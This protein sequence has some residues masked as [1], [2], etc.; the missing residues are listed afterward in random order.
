MKLSLILVIGLLS[1]ATN[2]LSS[3]S[4]EWETF[5]LEHEKVYKDET[6]EEMRQ[7][8]W[9]TNK[10][11]I[12]EHNRKYEN[13]EVSF[14]MALNQFSDLSSAEFNE[15]YTGRN[16][17]DSDDS[18]Q[19]LVVV[20][21]TQEVSASLDWRQLGAVTGVKN[22]SP[23]GTCYAFST[24]GAIEG[25]LFKSTRQLVSLS[26]QQITDCSRAYGNGGCKGKGG[27]EIKAYNYIKRVGGI[28][29]E[30][31]YPFMAR[32]MKCKFNR[33]Y[34]AAKVGGH[35]KFVKT[36][37]N[38][39]KAVAYYGPIAV[40]IHAS[41]SL[42]HYSGGV[43]DDAFSC[44]NRINHAVLVVGYGNERGKDYWLVKNSWVSHHSTIIS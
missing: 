37:S 13:G 8:I 5:K 10:E 4:T 42:K 30:Q 32:D 38:L 9:L 14:T 12:A 29:T 7:Q 40:G 18:D 24:T 22:Q 2:G 35:L 3:P 21:P 28:Q 25:Q 23:C 43:Y 1:L 11:I 19:E 17:E 20:D 44:R 41:D 39:M 27:H 16:I 33:R 31:S 6:D 36:E 15:M 34:I 26:E